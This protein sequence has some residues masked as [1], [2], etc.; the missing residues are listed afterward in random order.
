MRNA[1]AFRLKT[2]NVS[3][4]IH[5][6]L[7][8]VAYGRACQCQNLVLHCSWKTR[9]PPI[10]VARRSAAFLNSKRESFE[11]V[12]ATEQPQ[13][14]LE[15]ISKHQTLFLLVETCPK[16]HLNSVEYAA[17]LSYGYIRN[18][19]MQFLQRGPIEG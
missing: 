14:P 11:V 15:T 19:C 10:G 7:Q 8:V 9:S 1:I 18:Y 16:D 17:S 2:A 4:P 13:S 12:S 3:S 6:S 5:F